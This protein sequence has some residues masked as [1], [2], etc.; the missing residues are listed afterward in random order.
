M[1]KVIP[2]ASETFARI[3]VIGVGG[4]GKNATNHM[5]R[6]GIPSVEFIVANT[7]AQDLQSSRAEK[8]IHLGKRT[9]QGLGTGMDPT[10]GKSAAEESM[11]EIN[12]MVK[13]AD[14]IFIACGMGGG[15]GTGA[16][17]V[18]AKVAQDLGVLTV[19]VVTKPFTFEGGRRR[20]IAEEGVVDLAQNTDAIMTIPNDLILATAGEKTTMADAFALSDEVLFRAVSGIAQLI[21]KP[22]DINIDFA[23]IRAILE[24]SGSAL[25]GLGSGRGIN[26]AEIA[27]A[28]AISS[29]L[30]EVSIKGAQR[31]LFSI[32]SRSRTD[33]SMKEIQTIADRITESVDQN[34]KIIFGTSTDKD[35]KQGQVQITLIATDFKDDN[36]T[37]A[38]DV[39]S[40]VE[41]RPTASRS[42]V[43]PISTFD[44]YGSGN[45]T[46]GSEVLESSIP[47][48]EEKD[49][50]SSKN[51][52]TAEWSIWGR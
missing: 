48:K 19:G 8:K 33:L 49:T 9:T 51:T 20:T 25:L 4:S 31:V 42:S 47:E 39:S 29:P 34:A 50:E 45:E 37:A 38:E 16:A 44:Q 3:R 35:L 24:D 6:G 32:A 2:P 22:G 36:D 27:V 11:Q 15:T 52:D 26:K 46:L 5:M 1:K 13:G 30:L 23:D 41:Q 17:P 10:L 14:L 12:E 43:Q 40:Q 7:D 18:I 21:I 28:K